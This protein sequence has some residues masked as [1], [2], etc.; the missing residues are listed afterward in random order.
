MHYTV[1]LEHEEDG[2]YH[3]FAPALKGC[4]SQGDT[5]D[6]AVSNITEAIGLYIDSLKARG[7]QA[8]TE[9]FLIKPIEV[10]A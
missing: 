6:E 4:H 7:E 2:G 1:I 5:L 8:P 10:A 3:A 9:D